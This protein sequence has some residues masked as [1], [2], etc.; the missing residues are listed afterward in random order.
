MKDLINPDG[1]INE[2]KEFTFLNSDKK[3][4]IT[5]T[6]DLY[7]SGVWT[8]I[9]T[10]KNLDNNNLTEI[11]REKLNKYKPKIVENERNNFENL[12][13]KERKGKHNGTNRTNTRGEGRQSNVFTD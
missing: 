6:E 10:V 1:S 4:R 13:R 3:L 9:D 12:K 7:N 8:V 2:H 11:S 5:K